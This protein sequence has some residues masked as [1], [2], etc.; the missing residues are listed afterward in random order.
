MQTDKFTALVRNAFVG[1]QNEALSHNH[2]K[3]TS[4]HLLSVLLADDNVTVRSL[5]SRAGGDLVRLQASLD[6]SLAAIPGVTGAGSEQLNL[7]IDLARV[8]QAS[9]VESKSLG[10]SFLIWMLM[11]LIP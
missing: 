3:M 9:E 10:D 11:P 8:L 1:A 4:M 7:D 2:Q 6:K 5:I